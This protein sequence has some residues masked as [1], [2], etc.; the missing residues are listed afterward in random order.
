[1][2]HLIIIVPMHGL[3]AQFLSSSCV[4][5]QTKVSDGYVYFT[6]TGVLPPKQKVCNFLFRYDIK[7][8]SLDKE[9]DNYKFFINIE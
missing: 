3:Y 4:F 1:M 9:G 7:E 5:R 6:Y 2:E 8:F